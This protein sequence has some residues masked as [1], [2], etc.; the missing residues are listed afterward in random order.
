MLALHSFETFRK[1]HMTQKTI[2]VVPSQ[3]LR[4][5][6][7]GLW[8]PAQLQ[9]MYHNEITGLATMTSSATDTTVDGSAVRTV[10]FQPQVGNKG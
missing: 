6:V 10:T 4:L 3:S 8:T 7:D 9:E 2:I 1:L 5:Q